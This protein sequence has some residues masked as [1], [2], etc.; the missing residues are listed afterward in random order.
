MK[1]ERNPPDGRV[2]LPPPKKSTCGFSYCGVAINNPP[3]NWGD[4]SAVKVPVVLGL[5]LGRFVAVALLCSLF[6]G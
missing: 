3:K 6:F 4:F 2:T 1:Y 5:V